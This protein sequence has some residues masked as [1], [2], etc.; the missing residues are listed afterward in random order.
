M[1]NIRYPAV[2]GSF[3]PEN[4]DILSDRIKLHL[5]QATLSS[6]PHRPKAII[7]PHAGYIY[8][9]AIAASAYQ[10]LQAIS[11]IINRVVLI[12]PSHRVGFNGL[13]VSSAD[14]FKTPL[15]T[16]PID[17]EAQQTL[18]TIDG[19]LLSDQAHEA[20][21]CLEVQLPFL[22]TLLDNFSI[23][24]IVAGNAS[25]ALVAQA[26]ESLWG[27]AETLFVISSDLSHY[28]DY[29]SAQKLD[30]ASTQAIL[31]LSSNTLR[32]DNA[33]GYVAVNGLLDFANKHKLRVSAI[34]LR[35]SGD[36]AGSKDRVVGYGAFLFEE[37]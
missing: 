10:Y 15:G 14:C 13:A 3:Y 29:L 28:H 4:P 19:V 36:T 17:K 32:S 12:G 27:G 11:H 16:I 21:H 2:A 9:G 26:I 30:N 31:N 5:A 7:A 24:P 1:T 6:T 18:L 37:D 20:E 8:S 35:N 23:V 33:C 34:D 25:P 22:Q